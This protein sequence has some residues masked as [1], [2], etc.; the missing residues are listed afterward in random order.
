VFAVLVGLW[1]ARSVSRPLVALAR[2]LQRIKEESD[3]S[4]DLKIDR[5]DEIGDMASALSAMLG[6]FRSA[7]RQIADSSDL[8]SGASADLAKSANE[9]YTSINR[10]QSETDQ[11]ATAMEEMAATA[12][13]IASSSGT[14][15]TAAKDAREATEHGHSIVSDTTSAIRSVAEELTAAADTVAQLKQHSESIGSVMEVIRSIAEQTNLL[16]LNAA[17]E[18]ARAGEHGRGFAVVAD[19]VRTLAGRTQ[20]STDEIRRTI[21]QVQK[22]ADDVV[23]GVD[24]SREHAQLSVECAAGADVALNQ[25][26]QAIEQVTQMTYQIAT[27]AEEQSVVVVE[28][29][30]GIHTIAQSGEVTSNNAGRLT[31]SSDSLAQLAVDLKALVRRFKT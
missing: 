26:S 5:N 20:Q 27:A 23:L 31:Q 10:Q 13:E 18:A 7:L 21:E 16:A 29:S 28:T 9:S 11:I 4:R 24:R 1:F 2:E 19:E 14:A 12:K 3:L 6:Q 25:I 15:S 22:G 30:N 8:M 17:I